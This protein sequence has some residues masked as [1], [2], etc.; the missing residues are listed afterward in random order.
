AARLAQPGGRLRLQLRLGEA[1]RAPAYLSVEAKLV[2]SAEEA[3]PRSQ[4]EGAGLR[5]AG[6]GVE[7]KLDIAGVE[8]LPQLIVHLPFLEM[9]FEGLVIPAED[10]CI[11]TVEV[12]GLL[13]DLADAD[14]H[15][16]AQT[17]EADLQKDVASRE[18]GILAVDGANHAGVG[19]LVV[20][21]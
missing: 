12:A 17:C 5:S 20:D 8:P 9:P 6:D 19:E 11:A 18:R 10:P 7:A 3:E 16:E 14:A 13:V 1:S 4:H 15:V 2:G 21:H